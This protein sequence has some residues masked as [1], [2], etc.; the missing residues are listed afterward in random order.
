MQNNPD[1]NKRNGGKYFEKNCNIY[2]VYD[3]FY[4]RM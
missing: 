2:N 1:L 4:N 3:V